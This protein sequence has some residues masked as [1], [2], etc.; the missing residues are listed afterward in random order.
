MLDAYLREKPEAWL[1]KKAYSPIRVDEEE[2]YISGETMYIP[3][4]N[5]FDHTNMN[6]VRLEYTVNGETQKVSIAQS[7]EPHKEGIIKVGGISGSP[8]SVNLKFYT[9]D[10]LMADEY[11]VD[12][13][14]ASYSFTPPSDV[15]PTIADTTEA[16][17]VSGDEFSV[18]FGKETGLIEKAEFGGK[19]MITGG[20]YLHV[21]GMSLGDWTPDEEEGI[22]VTEEDNCAVATM[23]GS[24]ANGQG[25]E[26]TVR[27]SGNGIL[28]TDYKLTTEPKTTSGLSEVGVSYDIPFDMESVS[29]LRDGL[30]SAYPED[31]I[32]RN[33]GTALKVRKNSDTD[34][35]R[36]GVTPSWPWKDDMMNYFVWATDDPCNG[37]AT[38][39]FRSMRENVYYYNV[40]YGTEENAPRISVESEK[41]SVSARVDL[42]YD[43]GYIDDRDPRVKY[44]ENWAPYDSGSDYAGTETYSTALGASCELSFEGTGIR[45]IG[46]KQANV[47]KVKIYIDGEFK[48]EV[49]TFNELGG[50]DLKQ[51]EIYRIENLAKGTHKIKLETSGGHANCIV[52]DAFE[53]L[54]NENVTK[55]VVSKLVIDNQWYYPNLGWGN[56]TGRSGTLAKD[57]T[58]TATIRLT[59]KTNM[60]KASEASLSR[61]RVSE[62][63]E[64]T[65]KVD[66]DLRNA[67]DGMEVS[68]QW[69]KVRVGDPDS[70]RQAIE[71]ATKAALS[72]DG[73]EGNRISCVVSL[74]QGDVEMA[75]AASN[76][77]QVGD[78]RYHDIVKDSNEFVFEGTIQTDS[79]KSHTQNAFG[80][81]VTYLMADQASVTYTFTGSGIRW[82]GAKENNQ[83]IASVFIDGGSSPEKIDLYGT[84][85]T[86]N[87]VNEILYEKTWGEVGE[88]TIKILRTGDKNGSS[89]GAYVSLDAFIVTNEPVQVTGVNLNAGELRLAKGGSGRLTAAVLPV[90]AAN[91]AVTFTS[92]NARVATVDEEGTVTAVGAGEAVITATTAEGRFTAVC[93]VKVSE[94]PVGVTGVTLD[95]EELNLKE[96]ER[97]WLTATVLPKNTES[98]DVMFTTS[99]GAVATVNAEGEVTAEGTGEAVITVTTVEGGFT[100][101]CT[102]KVAANPQSPVTEEDLEKAQADAAQAKAAEAAAKDAL[103]KANQKVAEAQKAAAEAEKLAEEK[104]KAIAENQKATEQQ[105]QEAQAAQKELETTRAALAKAQAEAKKAQN[106]LEKLNFQAKK[107][108]LSK[109]AG[110]KKK[111]AKATWKKVSG[112]TGYQIQ[113]ALKSNFKGKKT[114]TVKG[115]KKTSGTIKKLKSGKKYYVRVRAYKKIGSQNAYTKFSSTKSV[116]VK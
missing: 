47:G 7:I 48:E 115:G 57:K 69:Y 29:W 77:V 23:K 11:Q 111:T 114:V 37:I 76:S 103:N 33:E 5:W 78:C 46:S 90:D 21:T 17:T 71:G 39:D 42:S 58:G 16:V 105:R 8:D 98:Q 116:K 12:L 81:T 79:N 52:V 9:S 26:F 112:A 64:G 30:Y 68:L 19:T 1:T 107:M 101:A 34:P 73:Q 54:G 3:V 6:E 113:Y 93:I 2:C 72:T 109:V 25:V 97:G 18:A 96:G 85:G 40:N 59:D 51:T 84:T 60:G 66:Y 99:D 14:K 35:D 20:P 24:Y 92:N 80:K 70:K 86:G 95:A 43:Y 74:K 100:A 4:K 56:Y 50:G 82:L 49:D 15:T 38:N 36:Y 108:T 91:R 87:Q 75:S 94:A 28:A 41:A 31:H 22:Q 44:D 83:G 104:A 61:V 10:G 45:F 65:L 32:G 53:I 13:N 63:E 55:K 102:V 27:I 89:S 62:A 106:Q 88:H 110:T 67:D